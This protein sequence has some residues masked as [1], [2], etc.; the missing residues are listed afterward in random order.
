[1]LLLLSASKHSRTEP[2]PD[3]IRGCAPTDLKTL[4][5]GCAQLARQGL[6][7]GMGEEDSQLACTRRAGAA[8]TPVTFAQHSQRGPILAGVR[9]IIRR[10]ERV[11]PVIERSPACSGK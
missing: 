3:L 5:A 10:A 11:Q 2:A 4:H 9:R 7:L 8:R 6:H 1:M